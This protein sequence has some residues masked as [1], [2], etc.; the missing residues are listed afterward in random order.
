MW[1]LRGLSL[2]I[3]P[4]EV[5]CLLGPSGC[6]KTTLLRVAA[7]IEKPS[8]GRVL[9]NE[10]EVAG[11]NR[12]VPPEGRNVGLMFQDFA[13]FPHLR[14]AE[15]V[16]FGLRRLDP[17]NRRQRVARW[18]ERMRL[19]AHARAWPHT[20]SGGE[21][22]RVA[23]ARALAPGPALMLLDEAFSAL[24]TSLR[25]AVREESLAVLRE[26]RTPTLL[27]THDAEEAVVVAVLGWGE[28]GDECAGHDSEYG[29]E[30]ERAEKDPAHPRSSPLA[31]GQHEAGLG[32]GD[33]DGSADSEGLEDSLGRAVLRVAPDHE[34]SG[35][36]RHQDDDPAC[37]AHRL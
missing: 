32:E 9:I 33:R 22:Q 7:G 36:E 26:S 29:G 19:S 37:D 13:L 31:E 6:G 3:A 18:L 27:V 25:A 20:L 35:D 12:F 10:R 34:E 23:L 11:P 17:A 24:D 1:A 28:P 30:G 16:A 21:Q 4:G 15:N 2:D 8:G 5:V 14:V